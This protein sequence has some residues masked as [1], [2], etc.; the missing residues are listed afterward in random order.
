MMLL[1]PITVVHAPKPRKPRPLWNTVI[2]TKVGGFL[3]KLGVVSKDHDEYIIDTKIGKLRIHLCG[4]WI[5]CCFLDDLSAAKKHFGVYRF[6][7]P[8]RFAP[9]SGKWN[10][11]TH[12]VM[13]SGW[14]PRGGIP[15]YE[16]CSKLAD[17][18]IAE[19]TK[20]LPE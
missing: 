11:H 2:R 20:I 12:D 4:D 7:D 15:S 1:P 3:D 16:S 19:L 13:P 5:A 6:G 8:H 17:F 9:I 18:F 14:R 10:F